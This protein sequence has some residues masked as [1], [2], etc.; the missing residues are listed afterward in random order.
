MPGAD[1][2]MGRGIGSCLAGLRQG[3]GITGVSSGHYQG[4]L[5]VSSALPGCYWGILRASLWHIQTPLGFHQSITEGIL[6]PPQGIAGA[7]LA[8][9]G[10]TVLFAGTFVRATG[11]SGVPWTQLCLAGRR[12]PALVLKCSSRAP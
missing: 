5:R 6:G 9:W 3:E 1:P 8:G 2:R 12:V 7:H 11:K 10:D 4:V